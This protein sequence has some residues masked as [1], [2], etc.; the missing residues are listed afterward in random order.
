MCMDIA[1]G[2]ELLRFINRCK[3]EKELAGIESSACSVEI[4]KFYVAEIV[5]AVLYLH[6]NGIVHRDIKPENIL[7]SGDGHIRITD[8]GTAVF[9][10]S[11]EDSGDMAR[12]S[13]VGTAEY[14]SP[15]VCTSLYN[16]ITIFYVLVD[17]IE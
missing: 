15:E 9:I 12:N 2:G 5:T 17:F 6:K 16:A 13:F 3:E 11:I 4:T 14:V 10:N 1:H 8:F 7:I